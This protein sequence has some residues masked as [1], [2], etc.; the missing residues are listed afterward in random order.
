MC[1]LPKEWATAGRSRETRCLNITQCCPNT[2]VMAGRHQRPSK[3]CSKHRHLDEEESSE[4]SAMQEQTPVLSEHSSVSAI[5]VVHLPDNN[6]NSL[7]TGCKKA[8]NVQ[9]FHGRTA[10]VLAVVRP[11]GIVVNF[12]E[13]FTCESPTQAY[14]FLYTTFGRSLTDLSRL[15]DSLGT[16]E[17]MIFTHS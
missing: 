8:Q 12:A 17:R 4:H 14:I 1:A 13:M 5:K 9:R 7:L 2:P 11:C 10:G 15:Y 3:Y 6:D 16:T